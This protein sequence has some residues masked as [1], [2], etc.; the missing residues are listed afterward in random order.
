MASAESRVASRIA[1]SCASSRKGPTPT[2]RS[3]ARRQGSMRV[4]GPSRSGSPT[5]R[6]SGC[7]RSTTRSRR[8]AERPVAALDVPVRAALRLGAYELAYLDG[9]PARASVNEAV[10]LVRGAGVSRATGLVNAVLRRAAERIRRS[11]TALPEDSAEAGRAQALVSRLDRRDLVAGVGR[12]RGTRADARRTSRRRPPCASSARSRR[13][14]RVVDR[15]DPRRWSRDSSGRRAAARSSR[16]GGR[17]PR[18]RARARPLR[19]ARR[20]GD[21][22]GRG[23][24]RGGRGR[25]A[26][27]SRARAGG[28]RQAASARQRHGRECRRAR[29]AR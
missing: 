16:A 11:S 1:C 24:R 12:G 8:S 22:A 29:A 7:G 3:R 10:E 27:R 23:G 15:I 19:G 13:R 9:V 25:A 26:S 6:S 20:E 21:A 18:G 2:G 4:T 28:E 14:T 5:A 17:R